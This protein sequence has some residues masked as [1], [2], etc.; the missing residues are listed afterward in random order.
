MR[1]YIVFHP[2]C[3]EVKPQTKFEFK[4]HKHSNIVL[5]K[6]IVYRSIMALPIMSYLVKKLS[7][8]PVKGVGQVKAPTRGVE[9][10]L[11]VSAALLQ[12]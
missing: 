9:T 5:Q 11:A 2:C 1:I 8:W 3:F 6:S 4:N 12:Q 7:L 10:G